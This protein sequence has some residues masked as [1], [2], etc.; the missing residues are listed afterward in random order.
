M[1]LAGNTVNGGENGVRAGAQTLILLAAP[2]NVAILRTLGDG[3]R[4]QTELRRAAELPAQSTLRAQLGRLV[5]LGAVEKRRRNRFPGVLDYALTASG[6]G[7][8]AVVEPLE[9]WLDQAPD[10]ALAAGGNPAKAAIKA[11]AEGWSSTILR[12]LS[13]RPLSLT[14]LDSLISALSYPAIER[15]LALMRL[16]GLIRT[17]A[18]AGRGTPYVVTDWLRLGLAPLAAAARWERRHRAESTPAFEGIDAE[19][20]FLLAA[21]LMGAAKDARGSCRIAVE[22]PRSQARFAGVAI[23]VADGAVVGCTTRLDGKPDAWALGSVGGWLDM[24]VAGDPAQLE[25]GGDSSLANALLA[26]LHERLF[27][28]S[29]C[30]EI[31]TDS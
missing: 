29:P 22:L 25:I 14:E 18:G 27:N 10:G 11:L 19:T 20:S 17:Q 24:I 21:P 15:R 9:R 2:L 26:G 1:R 28:P 4:R 7:L 23:T 31:R 8:L 5:E 30:D 13:T 16:A 6:R 12:A 3:P